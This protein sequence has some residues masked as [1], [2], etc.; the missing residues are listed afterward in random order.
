MSKKFNAHWPVERCKYCAG[1]ITAAVL[2][3]TTAA[4]NGTID[5][6]KRM[7]LKMMACRFIEA[8]VDRFHIE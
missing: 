3:S 1:L 2:I 8:N 5:T 7:S 6:A 4:V